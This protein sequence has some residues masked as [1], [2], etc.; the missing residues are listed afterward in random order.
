MRGIECV[1]T[2]LTAITFL[3]TNFQSYMFEAFY[4]THDYLVEHTNAPVRR[5]LNDEIDWSARLIGIKGCRGVGKTTFLLMHAKEL[6]GEYIAPY[7]IPRSTSVRHEAHERVT[8]TDRELAKNHACLYVNFNHFFFAQHTLFEFAELFVASGGRILLLDQIFKYSNWSKELKA[9]YTAFPELSIVFTGSTVMRLTEDNPDL[10]D[11]VTMYNLR[12]FSF[13]EYLNLMTGNNFSVHSLQDI[14]NN[15]VSIAQ[16]ICRTVNPLDLF[17]DY[18]YHGYYPFFQEKRNYDETLLKTMN[19]MLEVD[20]LLIKLIDVS[21]LSKIRQ[22]LNIMLNETPCSLNVSKLSLDIDT[23]RATIMNYIKY[24]KDARLLNLLYPQGKQFPQK[25][26]KVYM[27]NTNLMFASTLRQPT[28][29]EIAETYFYNALHGYHK[30]N[31]GD[32]NAMFIIDGRHYFNAYGTTPKRPDH[33]LTA[34]KDLPIGS[35]RSIPLWLFGFL[36]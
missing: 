11:I 35:E 23:S 20:V 25:P 17:D 19:M 15:H 18:L 29:Q 1:A 30:I 22:L 2:D 9:C 10:K 27:Q 16:E 13:R 36:Y 3:L 33:R 34:I 12:G 32:R 14:L 5:I 21:Y 28:E 8:E 26:R 31:S 7:K 4:K 24:L 6:E